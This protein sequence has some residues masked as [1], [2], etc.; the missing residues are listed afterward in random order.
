[1]KVY[2]IELWLWKK[3][4]PNLLSKNSVIFENFWINR[5]FPFSNG[6]FDVPIRRQPAP[7]LFCDICDEFDAHDTEDCPLQ[8]S[9]SPPP[10]TATAP[11]F[12]GEDKTK[13]RKLPPPRKYC[14]SCESKHFF[15]LLLLIHE[16]LFNF[17]LAFGHDT[18]ECDNDETF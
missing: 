13:V 9:D 1:M 10:Q 3:D 18:E 15:F 8:S 16:N 14:E 17:F 7:R 11:P 2:Q 5:Q 6:L 12:Q 4:R